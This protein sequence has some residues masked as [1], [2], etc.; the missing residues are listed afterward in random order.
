MERA[1]P[2]ACLGILWCLHVCIH[3]CLCICGH[4]CGQQKEA[5]CD[6]LNEEAK[7]RETESRVIRECLSDTEMRPQEDE[8]VNNVKIRWRKMSSLPTRHGLN[9]CVPRNLYVEMELPRRWY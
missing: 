7:S 9:A 1:K 5:R 6:G 4:V 2:H 3:V 8:L